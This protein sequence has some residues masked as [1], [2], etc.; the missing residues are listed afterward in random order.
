MME[1]NTA[2]D[3][4]L[5]AFQYGKVVSH[6]VLAYDT[7]N[8]HTWTAFDN[9][10]NTRAQHGHNKQARPEAGEP[11][12]RARRSAPHGLT[13][14]HRVYPGNVIDSREMSEALERIAVRL[15]RAGI[16]RGTVTMTMEKARPRW[17]TR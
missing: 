16:P 1:N 9:E 4:L 5:Q 3:R 13:M 17:T 10:H 7:T 12:V 15:D 6:R 8:L 11:E 2:L 14:M